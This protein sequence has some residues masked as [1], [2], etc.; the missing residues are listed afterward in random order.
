MVGRDIVRYQ[1]QSLIT[2]THSFCFYTCDYRERLNTIQN[3]TIV[4]SILCTLSIRLW[5]WRSHGSQTCTDIFVESQAQFFGLGAL[6][7]I[8]KN[9]N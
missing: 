9:R 3:C 1:Q 4:Q 5:Q 8:R 2:F 7:N 6:I